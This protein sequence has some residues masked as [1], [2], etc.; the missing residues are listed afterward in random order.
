[1]QRHFKH[2]KALLSTLIST[3]FLA[4]ACGGGGSGDSDPSA[5]SA[6]TDTDTDIAALAETPEQPTAK[7]LAV[8]S[9]T[10]TPTTAGLLLGSNVIQGG[11]DTNPAGVA[12]AFQFA[13]G[14]NGSADT[15]N[16][17]IDAGSTATR[18]VVGVYED[19]AG[20][21]GR[22]LSSA[23]TDSPRAGAWN[24]VR[25][26]AVNISAGSRYWIAVLAP[27]GYGSLKFRDVPSG[28][29]AT[30]ITQQNSLTGLPASWVIGATYANSPVSA[31]LSNSTA[32]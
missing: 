3:V 19:A 5:N 25:L 20:V 12:E 17:Y 32:V 10:V 8:T 22:L 14:A 24:A 7:A 9:G 13:A 23:V 29:G 27:V 28:G 31:Y 18:A 26:T 15:L 16:V 30:V 1:M 4:T 6:E 21:P 2:R 11:V